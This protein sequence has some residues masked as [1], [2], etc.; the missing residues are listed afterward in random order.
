MKSCPIIEPKTRHSKSEG[1]SHGDTHRYRLACIGN[2]EKKS[3]S[4]SQNRFLAELNVCPVRS[5]E[6]YRN[7]GI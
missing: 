6:F 5:G 7:C 3:A 4:F 1:S 2:T